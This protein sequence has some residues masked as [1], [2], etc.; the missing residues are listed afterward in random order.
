MERE[1]FPFA[2]KG[3]M[4]EPLSVWGELWFS[5]LAEGTRPCEGGFVVWERGGGVERGVV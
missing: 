4:P 3:G 1:T 5:G 2:G